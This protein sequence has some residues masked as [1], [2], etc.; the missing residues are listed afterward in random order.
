MRIGLIATNREWHN[1]GGP[2][3]AVAIGL[4]RLG[5]HVEVVAPVARWPIFAALPGVVF[6]WNGARGRRA[7]FV[8]RLRADGIPALIMERGFFDRFN[9]TQI[10]RQGFNHTASWATGV[11]EPAPAVGADRFQAVWGA[12]RPMKARKRGYILILLQVSDD[13]Q[14]SQS[15]IH[16]PGP[17]VQAVQ[18]AAPPEMEIRVRAH[19]RSTWRRDTRGR[20]K[21]LKGSLERAVRNARFAATINSGSGNEALALGC[22]VLCLGPALYSIAGAAQQTKLADLREAI[23]SMLGG[24]R[25]DGRTVKNY[26]HWLA[27]RQWTCEELAEGTVLETLL[28]DAT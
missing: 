13:A 20:A 5:H 22:P 12:R 9:F 18:D 14:L 10:D 8:R 6:V 11:R 17:F 4:E 7:E 19:P 26:L 3:R 21:I 24:W 28:D 16:H 27:S 1:D 25:P 15:E 2:H 23:E